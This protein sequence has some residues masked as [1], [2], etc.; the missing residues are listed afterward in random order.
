MQ[1]WKQIC[2][3][4]QAGREV[5]SGKYLIV[6][7]DEKGIRLERTKTGSPVRVSRAMVEKTGERLYA[8]EFIAKRT[9]S[10]T[11]AIE[12]LVIL[13]LGSAVEACE[14]DGQKGYRAA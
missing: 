4:F 5:N 12:F 10:Y 13:A 9:V 8:G 1:S 3:R 11:V 2:S 7:T 6:S 14:H